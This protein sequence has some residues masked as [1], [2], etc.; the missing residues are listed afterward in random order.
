MTN[1]IKKNFKRG[2]KMLKKIAL[3]SLIAMPVVAISQEIP[4]TGTV[5]SRCVIYTEVPGVYGNPSPAVLSTASV[6]GGVQPIVRYDVVQSGFYKAV[7][8]TPNSFTSSPALSDVV[9]WTGSVDV[10]RVTDAG[11]SAYSTNKRE[12]NNTTEIT[13][14]V[15]GSVWFKIDSK[16]EYGYNKAFPAG[17][18]RSVATASCIAI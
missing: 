16:A 1:D 2:K 14:T 7:I 13:L 9:R 6:D 15:P 5:T 12:Y 3:A 10:S 18:Y 4:I 11:M 8:T 17:Q